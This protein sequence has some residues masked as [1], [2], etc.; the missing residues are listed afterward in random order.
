MSSPRGL[1]RYSQI[2]LEIF[3]M[4]I[5]GNSLLGYFVVDVQGEYNTRFF[6]GIC[7]QSTISFIEETV[8]FGNRLRLYY[9]VVY[10][11]QTI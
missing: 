1:V 6:A 7:T 2:S 11:L 10:S 8:T 3:V 5:Y 4:V 9:V